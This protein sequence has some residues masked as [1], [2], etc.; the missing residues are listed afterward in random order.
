MLAKSSDSRLI[1]FTS[2]RLAHT[3]SELIEIKEITEEEL[4]AALKEHWKNAKASV[5]RNNPG[6]AV[7]FLQ[8]IL[9][10]QPGFLNARKLLRQAEITVTGASPGSAK[11]GLFGS[12]GGGAGGLARQSKKDPVATLAAIEKELEKDPFNAAI[13]DVLHDTCLKVNLLDTAAFALETARKGNPENTKIG[14]K[15]A[16]FYILRDMHNE[17]A[18]VF[19]DIVKND[20]SDGAAIKGEKDA[21]AKASMQKNKLSEDTSFKDLI[22]SD[23]AADLEKASKAALT[24]D[25]LL[26]KAANLGAQYEADPHNLVVVKDLAQAYEQLEDWPLAH[27][28]YDWAHQVSNGDVAL[29]S[30]AEVMKDKANDFT[31]QQLE[32]A[33][34]A[35]PDNAELQAQLKEAKSGRVAERLVECQQRVDQN[36][37]DPKLR[38]DLGHAFYDAEQYSEA[39]PHL[40]QATR[41]PHIRTKVLLLLGRT[42]NA[43]GMIDLSIKQLSDANAELTA[44]D[45]TKKEILYELGLIFTKADR[46]EEAISCFKQIYEVDY[47]Y[48]DVAARVEGSYTD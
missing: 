38:Y 37:T 11:K 22:K 26:E 48:R 4:P 15:L 45:N 34:A 19:R 28:F 33:A 20:P 16:Q 24:K 10:E 41:N 12:S 2:Q 3:M 14:H 43:K 46:M 7:K 9:K 17:A 42:F 23:E 1:E 25:Q 47:G 8:A 44:M 32:E 36:P 35:D 27:Q 6:Y 5:E 13:N 21:S 31:I 39:I 30:K 29:R 40:Q 18:N